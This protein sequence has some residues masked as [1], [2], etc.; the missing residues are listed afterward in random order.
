MGLMS[1]LNSSKRNV[2][3]RTINDFVDFR[4]VSH[5]PSEKENIC[6]PPL[7]MD[8]TD[9]IEMNKSNVAWGISR[10]MDGIETKAL[11]DAEAVKT[12]HPTMNEDKHKLMRTE[13]TD[14]HASQPKYSKEDEKLIHNEIKNRVY[15][16]PDRLPSICS[17]K[18]INAQ[19]VIACS[20]VSTNGKWIACGC[21]DS[22]IRLFDVAAVTGK[23]ANSFDDEK[24]TENEEEED[25]KM[26]VD[27][28]NS[29]SN[30]AY[31]ASQELN[32]MHCHKLIGHKSMVTSIDFYP[33]REFFVSA[34]ADNTVR[35][36][37][38]E[39]N[40]GKG[41]QCL[42]FYRGHCFPIWDVAFSPLGLYFATASHDRTARLWST[43][44][45][46][47]MRIFAGHVSDV[48]CVRFHPNCNYVVTGS[49]DRTIRC[50]D[51]QSGNCV[52]LFTGHSGT[53]NDLQFTSDGRCIV[54]ASS[55]NTIMV[56]D[57]GTSECISVLE[58]HQDNVTQ[59][60]LAH[61]ANRN[62][63]IIDSNHNNQT[64]VSSFPLV[65]SSGLDNTVRFWNVND[66][67]KPLVKTIKTN[68]SSIS[69]LEMTRSNLLMLAGTVS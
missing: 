45:G 38:T 35:L 14:I 10:Y 2:I 30:N 68:Y 4:I 44:K 47:P 42:S 49:S 22:T 52:R 66:T 31:V 21:N 63:V 25:S 39:L 29:N 16:G 32:N 37:S 53:V 62:A 64:E 46:V 28:G 11:R 54:S 57:I 56:W 1:W 40:I 7:G 43:D 9:K 51:I 65:I 8:E 13:F 24:K 59:V 69:H 15:A 50:W 67:E 6:A 26:D 12:Y 27:N 20:N 34:S 23:S 33:D 58:G 36:W 5:E 55:D 19:N 17:Y 60:A 18:F 41:K 48:E 3:I 61:S